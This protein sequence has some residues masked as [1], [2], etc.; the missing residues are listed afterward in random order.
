MPF[1]GAAKGDAELYVKTGP[2]LADFANG[3]TPAG[4]AP[5]RH[6]VPG[7]IQRAQ[8]ALR[9][10]GLEE[11]PSWYV[12]GTIDKIIPPAEQLFM[13]GG[14]TPISPG[15]GPDTSPWCPTRVV[16]QVIET[17]AHAVR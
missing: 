12:L 10:T 15:S 13:A 14:C 2:F 4:R 3:L 7:S 9:A 16:S 5:R 11:I 1:P 8:P 17:A 6:T